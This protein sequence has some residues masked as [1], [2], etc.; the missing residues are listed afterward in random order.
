MN[1]NGSPPTWADSPA[2]QQLQARLAEEK[3]LQALDHILARLDTVE[4]SLSKLSDV[5]HQGP[6][7]V[8]MA[9][10]MADEA[11]RQADARG[12][13]LEN[14]LHNALVLAEQLTAPEMVEKISQLTE[15]TNQVP[16]LVAMT[17]DMLDE[18]YR[19]A[20]ASG[21]SI[22][23]RLSTA[24]ALAEKLTAPDMVGKLNDLM[25]LADQLPGIIA[26]TVDTVDEGLRQARENGLEPETMVEWASQFG[27]AMREAQET[28]A[29]PIGLF[30]MV[31]ALRDKDRQKAMS[32]SLNFLKALG[33]QL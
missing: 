19:R 32:F 16:G 30:G 23:E 12:V 22:D 7:M 15:F 29:K 14:R 20:D 6:G 8:A 27:R 17:G 5:M 31:G 1:T 28:P 24:L 26:M 13:N 33:K 21:V 11:Y 2:G 10:D 4:A 25:T 18:A 9:A 3:T